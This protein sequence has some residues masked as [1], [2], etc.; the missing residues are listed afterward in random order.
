LISLD[1]TSMQHRRGETTLFDSVP[2]LFV[3][4]WRVLIPLCESQSE[5]IG[6]LCW[7]VVVLGGETDAALFIMAQDKKSRTCI[8]N[9][10][11]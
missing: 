6:D 10:Y 7:V 2:G 9:V 4:S 8:H 5:L 11:S 1:A 3:P